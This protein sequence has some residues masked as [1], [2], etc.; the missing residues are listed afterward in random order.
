MSQLRK[1]QD[2][3]RVP[4]PGLQDHAGQHG[5]RLTT[6][7]RDIGAPHT[8]ACCGVFALSGG[9]GAQPRHHVAANVR[10]HRVVVG[11]IK[12]L[13]GTVASEI[14]TRATHSDA[15]A[16]STSGWI[17]PGRERRSGTATR[18]RRGRAPGPARPRPRTPRTP[19]VPPG[20]VSSAA[21][22]DRRRRCGHGGCP[23]RSARSSPSTCSSTA[24]ASDQYASLSR[25]M[26][27]PSS[28]TLS[29]K[30][31]YSQPRDTP[32]TSATSDTVVERMPLARRQTSAASISRSRTALGGRGAGQRRL[33]ID[34]AADGAERLHSA[35]GQTLPCDRPKW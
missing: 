8:F 5:L 18:I 1:T 24:C 9:V 6:R 30:C 23:R 22:R 19:R 20:A 16:M 33:L 21:R 14:S 29:G 17:S 32:A 4:G 13:P 34:F 15:S 2:Q 7:R 10:Q 25:T 31:R 27:A 12:L 11:R 26:A 35:N 3:L 28:E